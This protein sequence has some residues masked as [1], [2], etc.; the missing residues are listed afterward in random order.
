MLPLGVKSGFKTLWLWQRSV[1]GFRAASRSI[2]GCTNRGQRR[3]WFLSPESQ[4]GS[5]C[6]NFKVP[7]EGKKEQ[8]SATQSDFQQAPPPPSIAVTRIL[9]C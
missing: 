9:K 7:L 2:P 6:S 5:E 4:I 3:K 8:V 1:E